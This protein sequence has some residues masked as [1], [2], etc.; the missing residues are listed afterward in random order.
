MTYHYS[1]EH[2]TKHIQGEEAKISIL[3]ALLF[4][5]EKVRVQKSVLEFSE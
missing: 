3:N 5:W 4:F 2:R 1:S